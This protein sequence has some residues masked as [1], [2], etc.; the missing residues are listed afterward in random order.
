MSVDVQRP[1]R[2]SSGPAELEKGRGRH[3]DRR[4]PSQD[5]GDRDDAGLLAELVAESSL[6]ADDDGDT[7]ERRVGGGRRTIRVYRLHNRC[8]RKF[9]RVA[10]RRVDA[11]AHHDDIY[12]K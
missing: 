4:R 10:G 3:S 11:A 7:A 5:G 2:G 8:S 12:S 6:N 9:V 1:L